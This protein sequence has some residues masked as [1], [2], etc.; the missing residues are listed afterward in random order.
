MRKVVVFFAV[1]VAMFWLLQFH[2]YVYAATDLVVP[3]TPFS[4]IPLGEVEDL[5]ESSRFMV[6]EESLAEQKAQEELY[7]FWFDNL[8][9]R[10]AL[11][12]VA[13]QTGSNIAV[14][15][16]IQGTIH[17]ILNDVTLEQALRT[18]SQI[19][20][21]AYIY[22]DNIYIF[23]PSD[24]L[25]GNNQPVQK[26]YKLQ[27]IR[28]EVV[29]PLLETL[30]ASHVDFVIEPISRSIVMNGPYVA[31]EKATNLLAEIDVPQKQVVLMT[32]VLEI[33]EGD[34]VRLGIEHRNVTGSAPAGPTVSLLDE[35][36]EIFASPVRIMGTLF[37]IQTELDALSEAQ[38]A[39]VLATPSLATLNGQ[40]ATIFL[41]DNV[42][43]R[44]DGAEGAVEVD[45]VEVG[46]HMTYTPWIN[47]ANEVTLEFTAEVE[48]ISGWVDSRFPNIVS[49]NIETTIRANSG[50]PIVIGGLFTTNELETMSKIPILGDLPFFGPLFRTTRTDFEE[51]E[52]VMVIV[53]YVI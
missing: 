45:W 36:V 9:L 35:I 29:Q 25:P 52:I 18:I 51:S 33:S 14:H 30:L 44:R 28:P 53:P 26:H 41:G 10:L 5:L 2:P 24:V 16:G 50:Q 11:Q 17:L 7:N 4:R 31:V 46:I 13:E 6:E 47:D 12:L 20:G 39:K 37:E 23:T 8:D 3:P 19:K 27:H 34:M 40:E 21:L 22:E 42:P 48:S 49:R 15:E 43:I 32:S 38:K 1:A